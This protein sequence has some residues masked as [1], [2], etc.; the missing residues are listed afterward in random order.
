[1]STE[2]GMVP[3][4]APLDGAVDGSAPTAPAP[5]TGVPELS[6]R[7]RRNWS[8][9]VF[10][11][12]ALGGLV[13]FSVTYQLDYVMLKPGSARPT[14]ALLSIDGTEV[15]PPDTEINFTTVALATTVTPLD[16]LLGW[17]DPDIDV[18]ER[19]RI[20]GSSSPEQNRQVNVQLMDTS[21]EDAVRLALVTLGYEVPVTVDGL[22]ISRVVEN[23][24]AAGL[25]QVGEVV[26]AID[27]EVIDEVGELE[28]I[29]EP[30]RV[31][32]VV[33]ITVEDTTR[34]NSRVESVR[35][36]ADVPP[37]DAP[38]DAEER[39]IIGVSLN[40]VP[41]YDFPFEVTI[42]AGSVGGPSAGLAFTLAVLDA[43]T[44]GDLA[45]GTPI[46]VTGT[47]DAA[48]NVGPIGGVQQKAAAV[49]DQGISVFLVPTANFADAQKKAGDGLQVIPVSTL[50]EAL[51]ALRSL[52]GAALPPLVA[53][54]AAE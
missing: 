10:G 32:D 48:G 3:T 23:S 4:T 44:E 5:G 6:S 18:F 42:D 37:A 34:E 20:L 2:H 14:S 8:V 45:G 22:V 50:S 47:I 24:N 26:T 30:K 7:S 13:V 28:A 40:L 12:L 9:V 51:N 36:V 21:K 53:A 49:R 35:L 43:L 1:M 11:L 29:M 52:G 16:A 31:G 33:E 38:P 15:F 19:E 27:G 54:G 17:I 46:A 39:A 41:Q 25:L